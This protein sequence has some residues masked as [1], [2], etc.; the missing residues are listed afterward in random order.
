MDEYKLSST[1]LNIIVSFLKENFNK[2][3]DLSTTP[4]MLNETDCFVF[5]GEIEGVPGLH[6][7]ILTNLDLTIPDGIVRHFP[8]NPNH[9]F[10]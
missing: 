8:N 9:Q 7:D 6:F 4:I 2:D 3:W 10:A 1:N 5:I